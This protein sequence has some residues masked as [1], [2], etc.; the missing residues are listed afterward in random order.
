MCCPCFL[1]RSRL[2]TPVE[3]FALLTAAFCHD[4]EHPGT[5][6]AY[7]V[8][9]QTD[10]AIRY[11]DVSVLENHHAA[12]CFHLIQATGFLTGLSR[13]QFKEVLFPDAI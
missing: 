10:L 6:N 5:N 3:V 1:F 9:S 2:L 12:L 11:N 8:N 7:Q 13:D 4:L